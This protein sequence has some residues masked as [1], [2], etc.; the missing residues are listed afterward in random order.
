MRY[1][2]RLQQRDDGLFYLG[3][4]GISAA[5]PPIPHPPV[6]L[7]QRLSDAPIRANKAARNLGL[8]PFIP[9]IRGATP[10]RFFGILNGLTQVSSETNRTIT[11]AT[12]A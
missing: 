6:V 10:N 5:N 11:F 9:W 4:G 2:H 3:L 8:Q 12:P 7:R 1:S